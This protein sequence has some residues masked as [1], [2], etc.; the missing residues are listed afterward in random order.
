MISGKDCMPE[1]CYDE[2]EIVRN[3]LNKQG[4]QTYY[5]MIHSFAQDDNIS[6]EKCHEIGMQMAEHCFTADS[7]RL[8]FAEWNGIGLILK[9][10]Y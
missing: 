6:P 3:N 8:K 4:G 10:V 2:F 7:D 9:V 5:H 1:S